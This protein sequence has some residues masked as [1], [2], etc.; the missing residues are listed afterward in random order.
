MKR[1]ALAALLA[2]PSLASC[3]VSIG[4]DEVPRYVVFS[5]EGKVYRVHNGTGEVWVYDGASW[6]SL[7]VAMHQEGGGV[8]ARLDD[9]D[10]QGRRTK[11]DL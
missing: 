2:V 11:R 3:R 10:E 4:G 1:S 8:R 7:G 9:E 5:N 6:K